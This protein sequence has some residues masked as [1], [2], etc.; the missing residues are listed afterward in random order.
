MRTKDELLP[1]PTLMEC[2]GEF[3]LNM[4]DNTLLDGVLKD[5]RVFCFPGFSKPEEGIVSF[6]D[7]FRGKP[8]GVLFLP[9]AMDAKWFHDQILTKAQAL[10]IFKKRPRLYDPDIKDYSKIR[11]L[12]PMCLAFFGDNM[13]ASHLNLPKL[14]DEFGGSFLYISKGNYVQ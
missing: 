3:N 12:V 1:C 13:W 6:L 7:H 4:N 14:L 2:L 8:N 10:F 9:A 5:N 11:S